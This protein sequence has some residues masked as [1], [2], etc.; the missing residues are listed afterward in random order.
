MS[1]GILGHYLA[2]RYL[3]RA[4]ARHLAEYPQVACFAFDLITRAIHLD[5]QYERDQ[6]SFLA[7]KIF[8]QL[9]PGGA[10]LDVGANIGNHSLH[11]A[12]HFA[13]VIAF[14]P[15]PRI[16]RLLDLNAD[17]A[18]NLTAMNLGASSAAGAVTVPE[19][20]RNLG[21]TGIG[22]E[23]AGNSVTF[24]LARL[25]DVAEVQALDRLTFIKLDVEGHE[26]AA[27]EGARQTILRHR[28]VIAIEVLPDEIAD[29]SSA[30]LDLLRGM[31]YTHFY[32]PVGAGLLDRLPIR[33]RKLARTL[34]A[35]VTG[36]RPSKAARLA[37]VDRLEPRSYQMLL[38]SFGPLPGA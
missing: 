8:P 35:I 6:L 26:P 5:G 7:E 37:R 11:F 12:R 3:T 22:R 34:T 18:P 31:G 36:R 16:F 33:L 15:H 25:D 29:G 4:N 24:H 23:A 19:N 1:M 20:P 30:S 32:E 17:L 10:C 2:R 13:R 28:P 9:P 38:G 21:A 14:E 27:L